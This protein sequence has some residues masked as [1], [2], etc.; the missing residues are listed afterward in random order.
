[1]AISDEDLKLQAEAEAE[2]EFEFA[3][4]QAAKKSKQL[5]SN[6]D[7]SVLGNFGKGASEFIPG[8]LQMGGDLADFVNPNAPLKNINGDVIPTGS[9]FGEVAKGEVNKVANTV[10]P[11][12]AGTVGAALAAPYGALY[13]SAFG[14]VGTVVGGGLAGA[15]GFGAGMLGF[16][17]TKDAT[18]EATGALTGKDLGSIRPLDE[19]LKDAAY[20]TGQG[21]PLGILGEGISAGAHGAKRFA[22]DPFTQGNADARVAEYLNNIEPGYA[23]QIDPAL[24]EAQ[25]SG[26]PQDFLDQRSLGELLDSNA[27]KGEQRIAA[28]GAGIKGVTGTPSARALDA[29]NTRNDTQLKW[30]NNLE[31]SPM[32]MEDVQASAQG[33]ANQDIA[34]AQNDVTQAGDAVGQAISELPLP[35]QSDVAGNIIREG[36]QSGREAIGKDVTEGFAGMGAGVVDPATTRAKAAEL[37]PKYF[38]EVGTQPN[39]ELSALVE[40]LNKP[41]EVSPIID[42]TTKQPIVTPAT[43]SLKDIQALRNQALDIA[44]KADPKSRTVAG[45]I[46]NTLKADGDNAVKSGAVSPEEIQSWKEGIAARKKQGVL[47]ESS[48]TP[49]K[50]VLAKQPYGEFKLP[51]SAIPEQYIKQGSSGAKER[52]QNYKDTYGATDQA[53]DPLYR[54]ATGLFRDAAVK[55]DGTI[56]S[57]AANSW[58]RRHSATLDEL[59]LL[60][61]QLSNVHEAQQ[62]LNEKYGDLKRTQKEVENGALKSLLGVDPEK[63]IP[64]MLSGKDMVK[65]TVATVQFLK[66][67]DP[68]A[69]AGLRRGVIE[70]LKNKAFIPDQMGGVE[71]ALASG[72]EFQGTVRGGTLATELAKIRPALERSKLFTDSQLKGFDQLYNDKMSQLSVEKAKLPGS[73]T[74]PDLT[75]LAAL[76]AVSGG[77][78]RR[79]APTHWIL[80]VLEPVLKSIPE[81]KFQATLENALLNPRFARDLQNRVSAKNFARS[82]QAIF[83]DDIAKAL[84][85]GALIGK[86]LKTTANPIATGLTAGAPF[87]PVV[88]TQQN[89][90]PYVPKQQA[91]T[92]KKT[93]PDPKELL[94]PP[95]PGKMQKT[96][97]DPSALSP[98]TRAR[99]GVE[100]SFNPDAVSPKGAVGLSQ[101][102][103]PT[104][105]DIAKDL[106]ETYMP[107]TPGM[108][109]EERQASIDQNIRFGDHY[110]N[111]MLPKINKAFKNKTLAWAAYNAGPQRVEDAMKMAG[112]ERDVNKILSNLPKGVQKETIPYVNKIAQRYG[113]A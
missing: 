109:D 35:I 34:R 78:L 21:A 46:A 113:S 61:R 93:M 28:R 97:F 58:L 111:V 85:N 69:L 98:E 45:E 75:T 33:I 82:A 16:D 95:A 8:T 80:T 99:V 39:A 59:P 11:F 3:Q 32:T 64:A 79:F 43:Y 81:A 71:E 10:G 4:K 56:D 40:G 83:K 62:F 104:A 96:S 52:I 74:A 14:P 37:M 30:L 51:E 25:A 77:F 23:A 38:R 105:Q 63:A 112:T 20:N 60:K 73:G 108:S 91:V 36:V 103:S 42:P 87:A 18:L 13:G 102:M 65:R 106:G 68:D 2:A 90:K 72:Q 6:Y 110:I 26:V 92:A 24:A 29:F 17:F 41:G 67:R 47:Y 94:S 44:Q 9:S 66:G 55:A 31:Q 70:H 19:Y 5:G 76:K 86:D 22:Y 88:A 27:L 12:A 100:S 57:G 101:L 89:K 15:A 84:G 1:M 53:L 7:S 107:I 49:A 50:A 54:Y 48:A